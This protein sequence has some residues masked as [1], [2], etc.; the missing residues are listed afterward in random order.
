[1]NLIKKLLRGDRYWLTRLVLQR[2]L[3]LVYLIAFIAVIHQFNPLLGE[4]GLLPVPRFVRK[5]ASL[6]S[7]SIFFWFPKDFAFDLFGWVGIALSLFALSGFSERFGNTV[8]AATWFLLW[9]IYLSYVNVG[10]T[11]YGFGWETLLLEAGFLAIF[12]GCRKTT[13]PL[14]VILLY[15]WLLF[16]LMFGAGL[17]KLRGDSCWRDL[18]CLNYFYETQPMPNPLSWY[19]HWQPE[20]FHK[21]C[22]LFN[23][24][25]EL[26][27]PFAYFAPMP[28][29]R[30]GGSDNVV[31]PRLAF[32]QRQLC[33]P[34]L[35]DHG[36]RAEHHW[37]RV[38][39]AHLARQ[40]TGV[41]AAR[42]CPL[43]HSLRSGN[44]AGGIEPLS[45][46]KHGLAPAGNER[47]L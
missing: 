22:V 37:R 45:H 6:M 38:V 1:M 4:H 9:V 36:H 27:V 14:L 29:K 19:F 10:Q 12:L 26:V 15:Q 44:R 17:I 30:G 47:L 3:A 35:S 20:W 40:A 23:H 5:S 16:R 8:S 41:D 39:E 7:P 33:L 24:F 18:T 25:T 11:F 31:L 43:L 34:W 21:L 42:P 46:H 2:G 13:P 28:V 32:R